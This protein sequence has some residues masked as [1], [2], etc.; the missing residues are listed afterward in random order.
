MVAKTQKPKG[1]MLGVDNKNPL[2]TLRFAEELGRGQPRNIDIDKLIKNTPHPVPYH[3]S[4][5]MPGNYV[6]MSIEGAKARRSKPL[7][8][9]R[10][11]AKRRRTFTNLG[12]FLPKDEPEMKKKKRLHSA[13][14]DSMKSLTNCSVG[15]NKAASSSSSSDKIPRIRSLGWCETL[16][17]GPKGPRRVVP[18]N[19]LALPS[20]RAVSTK[21]KIVPTTVK[22]KRLRVLRTRVP[23]PEVVNQDLD[24]ESEGLHETGNPWAVEG[25]TS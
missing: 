24:D 11:S 25:K 5:P 15:G 2:A 13:V 17:C 7:G 16:T 21:I 19:K 12:K 20:K 1:G 4:P 22:S 3:A 18:N 23:Q 8:L 6:L 10:P 14:D 9:F